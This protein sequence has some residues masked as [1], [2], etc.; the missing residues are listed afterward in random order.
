MADNFFDLYGLIDDL[1]KKNP[2]VQHITNYVTVNDCANATLAIGA[3]PVMA[4]SIAEAAQIASIADALVINIG[5][6]NDATIPSMFA[7][8]KAANEKGIP[9]ALDPVGAGAS[10]LR[11][12]T[13]AR[14]LSE[15]KIAALKGNAS[16]IR[17]IAGLEAR[18][19]GV[20]A[21]AGDGAES[22][23][24]AKDLAKRLGCTVVISG[25]RDIISDGDKT[26]Y[27]DNGHEMMG[28]ITGTGC[29]CASIVGAFLGANRDEPFWGA[30]AA[31]ACMGTSGD[32]AFDKA[33]ELGTGSFLAALI[34]ALSR[35]NSQI[36]KGLTKYGEL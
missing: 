19:K 9:I 5:T 1:R 25:P 10:A 26:A 23:S 6:L 36:I 4:D 8:G 18:S 32:L 11:S 29:M 33:G 14:L 20:D 21:G 27:I 22:A 15:L 2:L 13:T 28:R 7:A 12:Q 34:D 16:E 31:M 3:S 30:V 17:H 24:V 35:A